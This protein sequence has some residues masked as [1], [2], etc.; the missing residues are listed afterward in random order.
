MYEEGAAEIARRSRG[1][2]RIAN[3]LLRRVR[4]FEDVRAEGIITRDAADQGLKLLEVDELGLDNSDRLILDA[5]IT[6]FGGGP[7]GLDTLAATT[8]EESGTIEDVIEPFLC[9]LVLS[10]GRREDAVRRKMHT[11]IWDSRAAEEYLIARGKP[12]SFSWSGHYED[13]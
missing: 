9:S 12:G 5:I 1:T 7:V 10:S 3:R 4:D 11:G 6:K 8:G 2:P 13:I